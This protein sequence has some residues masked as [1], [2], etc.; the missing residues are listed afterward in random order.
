M[1]TFGFFAPKEL[2]DEAK[3]QGE[4]VGNY[5]IMD[6][7]A[8]LKW[9]KNNIQAFGGDPNN[10]TIFGESAGGLSVTWLMVSPAARG[11]FHKG[12]AQSAQQTPIRGMTEVRFGLLPEQDLDAKIYQQSGG[13]IIKRV[14]GLADG[15]THVDFSSV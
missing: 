8:V 13:E 6:Q 11:L 12:I 3:V 15:K 4:P 10:V 14:K 5:G 9:V 1:G 7:I 2:I